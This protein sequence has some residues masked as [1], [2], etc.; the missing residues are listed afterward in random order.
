MGDELPTISFF[1]KSDYFIKMFFFNIIY[2]I[3]IILVLGN[4]FLGVIV[5]TFA[6][7]RDIKNEFEKDKANVCFICQLTREKSNMKMIDFDDHVKT[8]HYIWNYVN[9]ISYLYLNNP[10]DFS[11][12]E[13]YVYEKILNRDISWFPFVESD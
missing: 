12:I 2:H 5:D 9:F 1:S 7:L 11:H 6:E 3:V 13:L 4:I 8:D 10:N